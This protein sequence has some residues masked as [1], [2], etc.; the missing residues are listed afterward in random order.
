MLL[1]ERSTTNTYKGGRGFKELEFY[2][3]LTGEQKLVVLHFLTFYCRLVSP[4]P[5]F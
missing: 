5:Y 3:G 2:T 4:V 1:Y